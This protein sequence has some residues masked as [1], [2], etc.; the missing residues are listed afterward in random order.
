MRPIIL[1]ILLFAVAEIQAQLPE[2][3]D[4]S[5][6]GINRF[7]V[8][9][10]LRLS[11]GI[12]YF[13]P[14]ADNVN[15]LYKVGFDGAL[16]D[17]VNLSQGDYKFT[18]YLVARGDEVLF[19]GEAYKPF[20]NYNQTFI[21]RRA[22]VAV[23][24]D[25]LDV[26]SV[27]LYDILPYIAGSALSTQIGP[28]LMYIQPSIGIGVFGDTV[29]V[30]KE[31][32]YFD[33][34]TLLPIANSRVLE[35][36]IING[37]ALPTQ[38]IGTTSA[39]VYTAVFTQASIY[40]YGQ[41]SDCCTGLLIDPAAVGEYDLAGNFIQKHVLLETPSLDFDPT[42]A[43]VGNRIGQR[44]Y[45]SFVAEGFFGQP[46][47]SAM[48]DI[49]DLDFGLIRQ[50]KVPDCNMAPTGTKCV[51]ISNNEIYY[52]TT[53]TDYNLGLYK[54]DSLLNLIWSKFFDFEVPHYGIALH[55]TPDGGV[56][57]ECGI[58]GLGQGPDLLKLYKISP[59]GDIISSSS[60]ALP[61]AKA[62]V[63]YPNPFSS[64]FSIQGL[65]PYETS[66]ELYDPL[67]RLLF[68]AV[69]NGAPI[70]CPH[71]LKPGTYLLCV[72]NMD[73]RERVHSQWVIKGN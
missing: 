12:L 30:A 61:S 7:D 67:G 20:L 72:H 3:S 49:R 15:M 14:T 42:F 1:S 62:P 40:V 25:A 56:I 43:A 55:D 23:L 9:H 59:A 35:R 70:Q 64:Q 71:H 58:S 45:S 41:S 47:T 34:L 39:D 32:S 16:L 17:S 48:I 22:V 5:S 10:S 36:M 57:L 8:F 31:Y 68:T 6:R 33:T 27:D 13:A 37:P 26:V 60:L 38:S 18:G 65:P 66:V 52:L 54:Y 19:V 50:A 29:V 11:D 28:L 24:N 2:F 63:V 44:I 21:D 53:S 69:S 51:A 4:L 73:T 46:C